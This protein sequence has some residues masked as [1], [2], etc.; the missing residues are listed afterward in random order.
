MNKAIVAIATSHMASALFVERLQHRE[1]KERITVGIRSG[2]IERG[3]IEKPGLPRSRARKAT[4]TSS[5]RKAAMT[6]RTDHNQ[7]TARH[8][9]AQPGVDQPALLV[10]A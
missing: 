9:H 3:R 2:R 6:R 8:P 1:A 10:T 4:A 5:M 7:A